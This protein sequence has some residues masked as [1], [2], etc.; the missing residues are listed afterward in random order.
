MSLKE[1]TWE[2]H[3]KAE[4]KE[5]A[6]ILMSGNISPELY[7]KYLVNQY[8]MYSILEMNLQT[9]GFP[10]QLYSVFRSANIL[11]DIYELQEEHGLQMNAK[12]LYPVCYKYASRI[13]ELSRNRNYDGLV[14]HMYVRHFGDMYGGA[15]I[16]KKVPGKGLMY[17]FEDKE[18]LKASL[19]EILTDDMGDE[20]NICFKFAIELFE[21]LGNES[22]MGSSNAT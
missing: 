2:N 19:R 13:E 18:E 16:S 7:H 21:E 20:A 5:F 9:A 3:K 6:S 14:A 8:Y 17:L 15:M 11:E 1:L 22:S 12:D 10:A 4:R